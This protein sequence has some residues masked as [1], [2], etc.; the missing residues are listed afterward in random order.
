MS[1]RLKFALALG[2]VIFSVVFLFHF[3][4]A[5]WNFYPPCPF[6]ILTGLH[7]PGCGSLR[8]IYQLLHCNLRSAFGLN[9]LMVLSLPFLGYALVSWI[10]A[11]LR[12]RPL[13]TFFV[14]SSW[15][16]LILIIILMFWI[17][18]NLP[19]YPFTWLAP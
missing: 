7:C 19:F 18:R 6:H 9:P 11:V 10:L 12:K 1:Q 5:I 4:P 8:A 13:P 14:P 17:L 2:F 15:I 3:D 16:W